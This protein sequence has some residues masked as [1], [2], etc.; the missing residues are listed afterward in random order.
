MCTRSWVTDLKGG[1]SPRLDVSV[2]HSSSSVQENWKITG[3]YFYWWW[4]LPV[5]DEPYCIGEL[6]KPVKNQGLFQFLSCLFQLVDHVIKITSLLLFQRNKKL[7]QIVWKVISTLSCYTHTHKHTSQHSVTMQKKSPSR[8]LSWNLTIAG[9]S[10]CNVKKVVMRW[11]MYGLY[12]T[13]GLYSVY[14]TS[15][16]TSHQLV[17]L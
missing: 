15:V 3:I 8:K 14:V 7:R 6:H 9:W 4:L 10:S 16:V 17:Y 12:T 13:T 11:S 2:Q 5:M 1:N